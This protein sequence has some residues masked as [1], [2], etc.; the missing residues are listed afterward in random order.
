[1]FIYLLRHAEAAESVDKKT[2]P[3]EGN[4]VLES[5][6]NRPLTKDGRK[7]MMNAAGKLNR[8]LS[9]PVDVILTSPLLRARETAQ[10]AAETMGMKKKVTICPEL[11]PGISHAKLLKALSKYKKS[12]Q[13]MLIGHAPDLNSTAAALLGSDTIGV[14]MKKGAMCCIELATLTG[15]TKGKLIW[16][17][18][19]KQLR[20]LRK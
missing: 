14:E 18:Q 11:A 1:M 12:E 19:P 17:M 13:L 7:K 3:K 4:D 5:D 20:Q 6:E 2:T 10:I 8:I 16:L 15:R 9:G